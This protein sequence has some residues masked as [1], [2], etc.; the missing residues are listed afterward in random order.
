MESQI[1]MSFLLIDCLP[2]LNTQ[3]KKSPQTRLKKLV[4]P[5]KVLKSPQKKR[6]PWSKKEDSALVQFIALHKDMQ[7]TDVAWPAMKA[8]H[9][10]WT[11]AAQYIKD[12]AD[13]ENL[14]QG[15]K[16]FN[17]LI[18]IIIIIVTCFFYIYINCV[19]STMNYCCHCETKSK[20]SKEVLVQHKKNAGHCQE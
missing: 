2:C 17:N 11:E 8:H 20:L 6:E 9:F 14:R 1:F 19:K 13:T 15:I 3:V 12:T 16:F 7:P 5:L 18:C 10:Y 4:S